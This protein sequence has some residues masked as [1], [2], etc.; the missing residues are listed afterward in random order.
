MNC[1]D[2]A[3]LTQS[4][5]EVNVNLDGCL[6]IPSNLEGFRQDLT[7]E[8]VVIPK[9][10]DNAIVSSITRVYGNIIDTDTDVCPHCGAKLYSN[11]SYDTV[12]KHLPLG[13]TSLSVVVTRKRKR[14]T[15][16]GKSFVKEIP[17][18]AEKHNITETLKKYIEKLLTMAMTLK[19][20]SDITGVDEHIIKA[21]DNNRL[22]DEETELDENGNRRLKKPTEY[23]KYIAVDEFKL[24]NEYRYATVIIDLETGYIL[25]FGRSKKK[26][27]IE[28]FM[29]LVGDDWM[30]HVEV[31]ACD[32][33]ADFCEAFQA[34]YPHID[35]VY[36][37]FHIRKN[38]NDMVIG[39]VRKDVQ[40]QLIREKKYE[41]AASLK[42]CNHILC[43]SKATRMA[44]EAEA[45]ERK[46]NG[47]Q[48]KSM[49]LFC[50]PPIE[51]KGGIEQ[52][53]QDIIESNK[54]FFV[55]DIIKDQL[56]VAY[57]SKTVEEM[58]KHIG[59]I[60]AL[61]HG[62][63]NDHFKRFAKLLCNHYEG[64]INFGKHHITS[65]KIEGTNN[66]IKNI[67]R[68]GYGYPDEEYFFLKAKDL[69]RQN[70][71]RSHKKLH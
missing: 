50:A 30:N 11:G 52:R 37:R 7:K 36:D 12:L 35:V 24:N 54:L 25:Y 1:T 32:M 55:M 8:V 13:Q 28:E 48:P 15:C 45:K 63:N 38:F 31:L 66:L 61:C 56:D 43:S 68:M 59:Q 58:S 10:A 2:N 41:E 6:V 69:S 23:A 49:S 51:V 40:R 65:G 71:L 44:I 21:I 62:T 9:V 57:S 39:P 70:K 16:C 27:V 33:N 3:V 29:K 14:C 67:R 34:K 53:Y 4:Y 19:A 64:V 18:K 46:E 47:N 60:I 42:R 26:V 5:N 17:F 20:I 22:E